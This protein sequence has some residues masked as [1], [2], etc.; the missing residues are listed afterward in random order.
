MEFNVLILDRFQAVKGRIHSTGA[1][2]L[3][4]L[5]LPRD[6]R[7]LHENTI[8]LMLPPGPHEPS[9]EQLNECMDPVALDLNDMYKGSRYLALILFESD[10]HITQGQ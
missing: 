4:I 3:T 7:Y 2:Y 6:I 8:L 9:L 1:V 10:H 5:N